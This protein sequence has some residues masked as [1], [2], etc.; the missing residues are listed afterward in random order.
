MFA[1]AMNLNGQTIAVHVA[2]DFGFMQDLVF[3]FLRAGYDVE[4]LNPKE[5]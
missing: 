4:W 1:V 2:D 5:A 3:R